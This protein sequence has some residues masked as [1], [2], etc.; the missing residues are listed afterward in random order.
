MIDLCSMIAQP[1]GV[2]TPSCAGC[3][4]LVCGRAGVRCAGVRWQCARGRAHSSSRLPFLYAHLEIVY[5]AELV[6][7]WADSKGQWR[8]DQ[9]L[10]TDVADLRLMAAALRENIGR[11]IVGKEQV[12]DLLL[13]ALLCEGHVLL[14]DVPGIGKTTLAKTLARSLDCL[15]QRIQ[16]TPD[17]LPSDITGV[18]VF[19]QKTGEF[20]FRPGPL[21]G[22]DRPGRRDQPRRPAHAVG[23]AGGHGGTPGDGRR[24]HPAAAPALPGAGDPEPVELEGTFPL[25]EAQVDRFLMRVAIGY[26]EEE[27]ERAILRRFRVHN[28]LADLP[29]VVGAAQLLHLQAVVRQVFVH[30]ARGAIHRAPGAGHPQPRCRAAGRQPARRAGALPHGTGAGSRRRPHLRAAGR[31]PG[32]GAHRC[33]PIACMTTSQ[34]RVRGKAAADIL[35]EIVAQTP[36]PVE[37]SWSVEDGRRVTRTLYWLMAIAFVLALWLREPLL[38]LLALLLG[39]VAG[40]T[41][42]WERYALAEV[43]YV[44]RLGTPRLFVG[45]ETDLTIE[46]TNAKPL[47]LAWLKAED[48]FPAEMALVRGR[49]TLL[50]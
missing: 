6:A 4:A 22:P 15:F 20:E 29:P 50:S 28:P 44:R 24:R 9:E 8:M 35:T 33:W 13:V 49:I 2:C 48:E 17:L 32:V 19:N 38:A 14:E 1:R 43:T 46:I 12:I 26:P 25:P 21:V 10:L 47:P 23:A 42:L 40:V 31:R 45:D 11:V 36:V 18:S 7:R 39:L 37:E 30:P 3:G 41:A 27:E 16:F 34:A 5:A